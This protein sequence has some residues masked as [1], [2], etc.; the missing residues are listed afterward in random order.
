ME[1]QFLE[2]QQSR[3]AY[4]RWGKGPRLLIALPGFGDTLSSFAV[5]A[6]ALEKT[7]T[8]WAIDLPAHG[9]TR[10]KAPQFSLQDYQQIIKL[11]LQQSSF[12]RLSL[13]GHSFGGRIVLSLLPTLLPRLDALYL[14][15]PDGLGTTDLK[16]TAYLPAFIRHW[17]AKLLEHP[18][19]LLKMTDF[20][21]RYGGLATPSHRFF[22]RQLQT[23]TQR[24]RLV[25]YWRS[26]PTF[27][28]KRKSIRQLLLNSELPVHLFLGKKDTIV[29]PAL[30]PKFSK[31]LPQVQCH[32][33]PG[34]HRLLH[35][36]LAAVLQQ[37]HAE[38]T[39]R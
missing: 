5:L 14:I 6:T 20:L 39:T 21:H 10:W 11:L 25:L 18:Q 17:V 8:V 15:A 34:G 35:D 32:L 27:R 22:Q 19:F 3:I 37:I 9:A 33:L 26:L 29:P 30:G 7:H 2:Y 24:Q 12:E 31:G 28:L 13:M 36:E 38:D 1:V 23:P 4:G 16:Y